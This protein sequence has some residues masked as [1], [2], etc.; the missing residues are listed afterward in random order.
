[1]IM[2]VLIMFA[3]ILQ[4]VINL[5]MLSI[6]GHGVLSGI[7][8]M[9]G[10]VSIAARALTTIY[11]LFFREFVCNRILTVALSRIQRRFGKA[12]AFYVNFISTSKTSKH[13]QGV[14]AGG[15]AAGC[16]RFKYATALCNYTQTRRY[17]FWLSVTNILYNAVTEYFRMQL[18]LGAERSF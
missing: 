3:V 18:C 9:Y 15:G 2:A 6:G 8:V 5:I 17:T 13:V 10:H 14:S 7:K 11:R 4:T 1:M 12:E 16:L